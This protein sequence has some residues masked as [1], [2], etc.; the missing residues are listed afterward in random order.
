MSLKRPLID[1]MP[2]RLVRV[3][4]APYVAGDSEAAAV[5]HAR[6]IHEEHGLLSTI[7]L[8][9][10]EVHSAEEVEA[11]IASYER[12]IELLG[13]QDY[14]TI[15]LKPTQLGSYDSP[16]VCEANIAR[17]AE[18]AARR[19]I[20]LT[21]DMEDHNY[22]DMTLEIYRNLLPRFP[23]LGTVL[24]SRL[25]RTDDDIRSLRGL[26]ARIR[27]CI[28]IYR[29]PA[30]MAL[31][32]KP[33]M[34]ERLFHQAA[35]LLE[36]G[37]YLEL[38]T[39]DEAL[40]DRCLEMAEARGFGRERLEIQMLMGVPRL[41]C[42]KRLIAAGYR[43]RLYVPYATMWKYAMAYC[44]RRLAANPAM[45]AYVMRNLLSRMRGRR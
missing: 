10:E 35:Q 23:D 42:Q 44:K 30:S 38:A 3:F 31:Q 43:V 41:A 4:A 15:S 20:P 8:L 28:G 11:T 16:Q 13:E 5:A 24:Q 22:T 40:I 2:D 12:V 32:S 29:E 39:H 37:H 9:G 45:A 21:I 1:A 25:F 33:E 17:I 7:D 34:K 27:L 6:R 26:K 18:A 19:K 36:D 14:A